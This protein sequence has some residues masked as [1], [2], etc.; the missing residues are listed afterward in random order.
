MLLYHYIYVN[1][2]HRVC[3]SKCTFKARDTRR[4]NMNGTCRLRSW[5]QQ[6]CCD[7]R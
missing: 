7:T 1:T 6:V 4:D 5:F 3:C 2:S